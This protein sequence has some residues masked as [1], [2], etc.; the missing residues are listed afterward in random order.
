MLI[1]WLPQA[2]KRFC[3]VAPQSSQRR[4]ARLSTQVFVLQ[5]ESLEDRQLLSAVNTYNVPAPSP[6]DNID[7]ILMQ[8]ASGATSTTSITSLTPT[9]GG[10]GVATNAANPSNPGSSQPGLTDTTADYVARDRFGRVG[11]R[12]ISSNVNGL[13]SA[14]ASLG[15]VAT[16]S[17]PDLNFVEGFIPQSKIALLGSL[18]NSGLMGVVPMYAAITR[19]GPSNDQAV[20]SM[21]VD[22]TLATAPGYDG[23]GVRIGVISD[24]FNYGGPTN[25]PAYSN[26]DLPS[27]VQ[28]LLEGPLDSTDEGRGMAELI[29]DTA[30][31]A[32]ISFASGY[33]GQA[34]MAQQI[35][36]LANPAIGRSNIIV[37]DLIYFDEPMFQDGV[38]AQ[39]VNDVVNFNGVSYFSAA[40]NDASQSYENTSPSFVADPTFGPGLYLDFDP[41]GNT[42]IRNRFT[43]TGSMRLELQWDD[44][45]YTTTGVNTD[46]DIFVVD[47]F[48]GEIIASSTSDNIATQT[49]SEFIGL[50]GFGTVDIIIRL[51]S[52]LATAPGRLKWVDFGQNQ[53]STTPL[54][55][56]QSSTVYGHAA[57]KGAMAVAAAPY[58]DPQNIEP[59]SSQGGSTILFTPTGA[60]LGTPD[61]RQTPGITAIDAANTSFFSGDFLFRPQG[62][63]ESDGLPNFFG[64]SAAAPHAAAVAALVK[65]ANP[66]MTPQQI[67]D[68]LTSTAIDIGAPGVDNFTG[69]GLINAFAALYG[70]QIQGGLGFTD[71]FE[72]GALTGFWETSVDRNGLITV[73]TTHGATD[74]T[75]S[76]TL[77]SRLTDSNS[78]T[79]DFDGFAVRD[80]STSVTLNLD[81]SGITDDV[82]LSFDAKQTLTNSFFNGDD[83]MP[84]FFAFSDPSDGVAIS[85]DGGFIWR[86]LISLTG[87]QISP[88]F[89]NHKINLTEMANNGGY[90]LQNG[91]LIRFQQHDELFSSSPITIDNV[92]LFTTQPPTVTLNPAP[93]N[94][95]IGSPA[96]NIDANAGI[97]DTQT[98]NYEGGTL[99]IAITQNGTSS[100]LIEIL[101]QALI[102]NRTPTPNDISVTG[103]RVLYGGVQIGTFVGGTGVTPLTIL[104]NSN[105]TLTAVRYLLRDI[106]FRT[107]STSLLP[108]TVSVTLD[109]GSGPGQPA[110][111]Q[112]NILQA[113]NVAPVI[114]TGTPS[115]L[116][117]QPGNTALIDDTLTLTDN[118]SF[119]FAGGVLTVKIATNASTSTDRIEIK[120]QGSGTGQIGFSGSTIKYQGTT[121]GTLSGGTTSRTITFTAAA[122]PAA[123]QALLRTITFRTTSTSAPLGTRSVQL[124]MSDGDGGTSLVFTKLINVVKK[125]Q[126]PVIGGI[127]ATIPIFHLG[128]APVIVEPSA[129][130]T[131]ADTSNFNG[132]SLTVKVT[133]NLNT[134]DKLR[135]RNQGSNI[136]QI[137]ISGNTTV[138]Y[139]GIAIGTISGGLNGVPLVITLNSNAN[140]AAVRA[141]T[142]NI[143]FETAGTN[144]SLLQRTI[145]FQ[146]N[147]GLGGISTAVSKFVKVSKT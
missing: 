32:A 12:I 126:A 30:P 128:K 137:A 68:R 25:L 142:R 71:S 100:D 119:N 24:S 18:S 44:P 63:I 120:N 127:T 74:G 20:A 69:S 53:F 41:S 51:E 13:Q 45:F 1:D 95:A 31:G 46:I 42:D 92:Q 129:T 131:D 123:V 80:A 19:A 6:Y 118:D 94:Y 40:G 103:N 87:S 77:G 82:F 97:V 48:T 33:Y 117:V 89:E 65:Q 132:G 70:G 86:K 56:T 49:P 139:G 110:T 108:R 146:L 85:V 61:V 50:N 140:A 115:A 57:A 98:T 2:L 15:F 102:P 67:Y 141:L 64:T 112:L 109:N 143:T 144:P 22:R 125:N 10:S 76:L 78:V 3:H 124:Q 107:Q 96:I 5:I 99:K 35:R 11:V 90:S 9:S 136:G 34:S 62:D 17:R 114:G 72:S 55:D 26:G 111:R 54:Y 23:T 27:S 93:L 88:A 122:T 36:N 28:V 84:D 91:V 39:A 14:L 116:N 81:L 134:F 145:S 113:A 73:D 130:I 66:G 47:P 101:N 147:D 83:V 75:G 104:F 133:T 58:Y 7:P 138:L 59:F 135:V 105:S 29:H 16:G 38:I 8:I 52:P 79:F 37:D 106:T 21:G 60:P 43:V 4:S 121:I